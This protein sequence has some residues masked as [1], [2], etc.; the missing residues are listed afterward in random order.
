MTR[1]QVEDNM[2]N[3][4]LKFRIGLITFAFGLTAFWFF[5]SQIIGLI[6]KPVNLPA[7]NSEEILVVF[8]R[9][10]FE[11]NVSEP[12]AVFCTRWAKEFPNSGRIGERKT[13]SSPKIKKTNRKIN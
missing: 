13:V 8:P 11:I 12:H 5:D 2:K 6:D 4:Y 1:I 10:G 3:F 9:V 7:T